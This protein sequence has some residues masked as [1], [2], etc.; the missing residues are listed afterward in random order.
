[1]ILP[2]VNLLLDAYDASS[3]HHGKA[4]HWW[5]LALL[6]AAGTGGHL[7][8]DAQ[9][10]VHARE[11]GATVFTNDSDFVRFPGLKTANPLHD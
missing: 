2:D 11:H 5:T 9:I 7:V 3:L 4:T 1:M 10:A 6:A 8:T